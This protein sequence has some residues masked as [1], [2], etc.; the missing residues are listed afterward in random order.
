MLIRPMVFADRDSVLAMEDALY[1]TSAIDHPVPRTNME[2]AFSDAVGENPH[3][4]GWLIE[5]DQQP[6]GFAYLTFFYSCEAGGTVVMLEE[7]FVK[8]ELRG[9]GVGQKFME[10]MYR[11]YPDA[12]RFR[13]E[14]T[15]GNPAAHLY[16]RNGF[17]LMDYDQMVY[18]VEQG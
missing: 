16:T 6:A 13:L 17:Q 14:V 9:Q 11:Q 8:D 18:N 2:R 1:H 4:T 10:W 15:H 7:L 12:V 5:A 3:L